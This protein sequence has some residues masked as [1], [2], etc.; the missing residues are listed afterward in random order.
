[1]GEIVEVFAF[2]R[3]SREISPA[4]AAREFA[5]DVELVSFLYVE[6]RIHGSNSVPNSSK[7]NNS[8]SAVAGFSLT[9]SFSWVNGD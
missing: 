1:V 4:F 7:Q 6:A 8:N 5:A 9:P 3:F 2:D